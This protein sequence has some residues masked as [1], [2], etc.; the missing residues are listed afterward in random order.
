MKIVSDSSLDIRPPVEGVDLEVI[1]FVI[2]FDNSE[3]RDHHW[4]QLPEYERDMKASKIF[5][6]ACP[7][8]NEYLEAFQNAKGP[9]YGITISSLLSGSYNSAI[10]GKELYYES[11]GTEKIHIFDSRSAGG[12][13]SLIYYKL[14][15][16]TEQGLDFEEIVEKVEAYRDSMATM[17][18]SESLDNLAKAG[19]L[20]NIKH[21]IAKTLNILPVM[22][23]TDEG[24]I[25]HEA[26]ARGSKQAFAKMVAKLKELNPKG[27]W[28]S[29]NHSGNTKW[30]NYVKEEMEKAGVSRIFMQRTV[31]LNTI[32]LDLN[33]VI[34]SLG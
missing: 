13:P 21:R 24:Q 17:F 23:A 16:L 11:G 9:I 33:G 2:T 22:I 7:S 20:S 6:T 3:Y 1:P 30:A 31:L 29:I 18:V 14:L 8:P 5:K 12:G 27:K 25:I 19:R 10:L 26:N 28:L 32:Y 34:V 15:E 4:D